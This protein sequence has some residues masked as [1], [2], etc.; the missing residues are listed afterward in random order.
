MTVAELQADMEL[1]RMEWSDV[2]DLLRAREDR[3]RKR[4][5]KLLR[6]GVTSV[7]DAPI[8]EDTPEGREALKAQM[9]RRMG[10]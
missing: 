1:I 8:H 5:A 9:R 6:D 7:V 3:E 10:Q 2:L 4:S